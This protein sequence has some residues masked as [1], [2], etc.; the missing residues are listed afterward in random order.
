MLLNSLLIVG[1]SLY[2]VQGEILRHTHVCLLL[3][4][5]MTVR[6]TMGVQ[7]SITIMAYFIVGVIKFWSDAYYAYWH[8]FAFYCMLAYSLVGVSCA[9]RIR[10][11]HEQEPVSD[12]PIESIA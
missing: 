1:V 7:F 10:F 2:I 6:Q 4:T 3:A 8:D 5:V 12:D 11:A 9:C